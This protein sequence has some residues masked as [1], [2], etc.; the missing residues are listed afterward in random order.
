[1]F[2]I[3]SEFN[4]NG[5]EVTL[6]AVIKLFLEFKQSLERRLK[7]W[8]DST[9]NTKLRRGTLRH[10]EPKIFAFTSIG[11]WSFL[12]CQDVKTYHLLSGR[13]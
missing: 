7:D 8:K 3:E 5:H 4:E 1:M 13:T 11:R 9:N 6:R 2:F 10:W 12:T